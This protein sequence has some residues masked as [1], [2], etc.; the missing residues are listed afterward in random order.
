[1]S[2]TVFVPVTAKSWLHRADGIG[3]RDPPWLIYLSCYNR[4]EGLLFSLKHFVQIIRRNFYKCGTPV[5]ATRGGNAFFQLLKK[6][7]SLLGSKGLGGLNCSPAGEHVD[8]GRK[9]PVEFS[10]FPPG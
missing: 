8:Q 7:E 2:V 6:R 4:Q 5:R 9:L 10:P 1:M 3:F